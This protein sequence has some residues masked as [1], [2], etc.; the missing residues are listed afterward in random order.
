MRLRHCQRDGKTLST[1][2]NTSALSATRGSTV[3]TANCV[4]NNEAPFVANVLSPSKSRSSASQADSGV[5]LVSNL[6]EGSEEKNAEHQ[7]YWRLEIYQVFSC[8][9]H[10]VL[11]SFSLL[12]FHINLFQV[13]CAS[14]AA[15]LINRLSVG[16]TVSFVTH[17]EKKYLETG[18]Q[19]YSTKNVYSCPR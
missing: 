16:N 15:G 6:R 18:K 13:Y 7:A 9:P 3:C 12:P 14:S 19:F 11:C 8:S 1:R 10:G 5:P 4:G 2:N 17:W